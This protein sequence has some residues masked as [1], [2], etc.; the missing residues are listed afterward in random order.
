MKSVNLSGAEALRLCEAVGTVAIAGHVN[1]DGDSLGSALALA[2]LLRGLGKQV[3]VLMGQDTPPPTLYSFLPG[4]NFEP[5]SGYT[6]TPELFIVVDSATIKRLGTARPV[7]ERSPKTLVIDHH[8]NYE[9]FA[10]YYF[11]DPDIAATGELIWQ[12]IRASGVRPSTNMAL[13]CY[14]A[15]LTDTG[16]FSY[17]KTS[18]H[19]FEDAKEM[20]ELGVNPAF[21]A[22]R[23]Y[24]SKPLASLQ[25]EA[26][27]IER[28]RFCVDGKLVYSYVTEADLRELGI[29]RDATEGL[30]NVLRSI[31]GVKLAV[32]LRYE[33][34]GVRVNLRSHDGIDVG[35]LAC[36]FGGGG[37]A[38]AAGFTLKMPLDESISLVLP[39]LEQLLTS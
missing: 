9:D 10:D 37:H 13:Y 39:K 28:L 36:G 22:S 5:A 6:R 2:E 4:Y 24:E 38:A 30:P 19:T 1:P 31:A 8:T 21:V 25:L 3:D 20:V 14:V 23:V 11:G 34:D 27:L 33:D 29:N 16:R 15:I 32:L 17:E 7:F 26:R 35:S 12:L 18:S